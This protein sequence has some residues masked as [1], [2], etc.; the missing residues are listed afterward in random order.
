SL[1]DRIEFLTSVDEGKLKALAKTQFGITLRAIAARN[2]TLITDPAWQKND[3]LL[4]AKTQKD[5]N[6]G[7]AELKRL[8]A[9]SAAPEAE[10]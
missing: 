8:L 10:R 3:A 7:L 9:E 2:L 5:I 6:D 4:V 1:N